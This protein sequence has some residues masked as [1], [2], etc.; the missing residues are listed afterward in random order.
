MGCL[1][2]STVFKT[3]NMIASYLILTTKALLNLLIQQTSSKHRRWRL[4]QSNLFTTTSTTKATL[5]STTAQTTT[6]SSPKW[7]LSMTRQECSGSTT[8]SNKKHSKWLISKEDRSQI[9]PQVIIQTIRTSKATCMQT[10]TAPSRWKA[11]TK[12]YQDLKRQMK[13]LTLNSWCLQT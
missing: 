9:Q 6:T 7:N 3:I 12:T 1:Q 11:K 4:N 13:A 10:C 8:I 2:P 5:H